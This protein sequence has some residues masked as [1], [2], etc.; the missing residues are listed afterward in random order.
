VT[1]TEDQELQGQ[2]FRGEHGA[3]NGRTAAPS[4]A[5][6]ASPPPDAESL[7]PLRRVLGEDGRALADP[8]LEP[9]LMRRIL[10]FM[11]WNRELDERLTKLQRQGRIG[12]HIGSVGEEATMI[13]TAAASAPG[14]W[15]VPCYRE[16]GV[17]LYRGMTLDQILANM[18]GTADDP[19]KGRQMP[20][21]YVDRAHNFLSIS[22]PV[23]TQIPQA[24][25]I[26]WA[27][28]LKRSGN[29]ALVYF[30]DGATSQGD[31]HVG[32]NFAGV[33]KAS[34]V[35]ICRN[36]RWAIST[37]Y[38]VQTRTPTIAQKAIAYGIIGE[39]VDGNDVLAVYQATRAA[40][41]RARAGEGPT[42][43]ELCTYRLGAHSTSD[44]PRAYRE[45]SQVEAWSKKD[46]IARF[47]TYLVARALWT[48]AEEEALRRSIAEKV[49]AAI[50]RA[51]S[52]PVP[53][54]DS[55]FRDVFAV[56]TAALAEQ[57]AEL[58]DAIREMG[59]APN[60]HKS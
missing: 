41:E 48:D 54:P 17:A 45:Q 35:F 13:G 6:I 8:G 27:M 4:A 37:P 39:R 44:D 32:L 16:M 2:T 1:G 19:V 29:A 40:L 10:E 23:G 55:L 25:G 52:A 9:A 31:F 46:P 42:L 57:E 50:A 12:F 59:S 20:C 3:I 24:A 26:G 15:V 56:R 11:I 51:E 33:Y 5:T 34:T 43:L 36:N 60:P 21:H 14:D 22:S 18:Y 47:R 58:T 49:Q 30:G 7:F 38:E 28:R 53:E